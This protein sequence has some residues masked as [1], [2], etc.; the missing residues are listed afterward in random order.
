MLCGLGGNAYAGSV[1]RTLLSFKDACN[2]TELATHLNDHLLC[3]TAHGVHGETA[4]QE[5]HHG[6]NEY[7]H[8]NHGVHKGNVIVL[9]NIR[10]AAVC[11]AG[12][13]CGHFSTLSGHVA[14]SNLDFLNVG[15]QEGKCGEG[16]GTNCKALTGCSGGVAKGVK[17]ICLLTHGRIQLTHLSVAAGVIRD[18][19]VSV[20]SQGDTQG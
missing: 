10:D 6:T 17:D 14:E 11:K 18:G 5:C 13:L 20:C 19:A 15:G 9:Y 8:Q 2:L 4:E 1:I 3:S 7:A 12:E 16:C